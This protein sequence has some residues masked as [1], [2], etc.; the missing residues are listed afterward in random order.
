MKTKLLILISMLLVG[1]A[2]AQIPTNGLI[3]N[4]DFTNG[5]I[6]TLTQN[7]TSL[8]NIN[9]RFG[10]VDN[11]VS[12]NGDHLTRPDLVLPSKA[13]ISFWVKTTNSDT[14]V[15]TIIDDAH[16]RNSVTDNIDNWSGYYFALQSGKISLTVQQRFAA[17]NIGIV[18][19]K[20][21][22]TM[23]VADGNWHHVIATI[24]LVVT[25]S[26]QYRDGRLIYTYRT[27]ANLYIDNVLDQT[28]SLAKS[29][30]LGF[31][32]NGNWETNG[33][34][35]IA[36]NR[37]NS[38]TAVNRYND[39][40]DEVLFYNR[41]LSL[42]EIDAVFN[43]NSACLILPTNTISATNITSNSADVSIVGSDTYDVAYHKSSEA[44]SNAVIV[45]SVSTNS[46]TLTNL[47]SQSEYKV[48]IKK[49]GGCAG[50]SDSITF[51]TIREDIPYYVKKD[52]TGLNDGS[53]WA[54][55]FTDLQVALS[56]IDDN[57][58][59]WIAQGTYTPHAS[60]RNGS[61]IIDKS[62]VEFYGG[63]NG[64]ETTLSERDLK[65]S[66]TILSGDLAGNDAGA[67]G[68]TVRGENAY[69]VVEINKHG[70]VLDGFTIRD[71]VA[72]D[73]GD[74]AAGGA[75]FKA[76][77][78]NSLT[79][80]NCNIKNNVAYNAA[81]IY[82]EFTSGGGTLDIENCIFDNN[83]ARLCT[84]FSAWARS[85]GTFTF[86][87]S[88]SLFSNNETRDLSGSGNST[89]GSS[90]WL[91]AI[92][93]GSTIVNASLINNTYVNNNDIGTHSSMSNTNRGTVG[94]STD[95]NG[96]MNLE[97]ANS[98]F[99]NNTIVGGVVANSITGISATLGNVTVTNSIDEGSFSRLTAANLTNTSNTDPLLKDV[100]NNEFILL[101]GSPAINTGDNSKLPAL[102]TKD[103]LG[104]DRIIE[105]IVDMGPYEF[106]PYA[107]ITYKLNVLV[108]GNG[109]V[110]HP[111]SKS[112]D[113]GTSLSLVAT[114]E[115]GYEFNGWTGDVVGN[116]NTLGVL[117]NNTL[118]VT[119]NFSKSRM[120]VDANATGNNNGLTWADA[121]TDL[122]TALANT[123]NNSEIWVAGG[124]YTPSA[125]DS[126]VYYN[127]TKSGLKIYGGFA[128]TETK[129]SDRIF[130]MNETILS[131]DLQGNDV[132]V[133]GYLDNY[134][135]S[136]R[137]NV[138][139]FHI[140]NITAT[141]NDLLLD[142]LT[143]SDAH[144]SI[145]TTEH[146]G[147]IVKNI[148]VSKLT[149]K[150]CI[151]KNNVSRNANAGLMAEFELNNTAGTRGLLTIENC[152]FTNNMSRYGTS[153]YSAIKSNTNVD[154]NIS[155]TLFNNNT[156]ADLTSSALAFS[157][158]AGWFRMLGST[159]DVNFNFTNNTLVNNTD[160]GTQQSLNASTHAVLAISRSPGFFGT[161][162]AIISNSIFWNNKT[163][164]GAVTRS[165][166]D[167]YKIPVASVNVYNS[168]DENNFNDATIT[169]ATAT[170]DSDPL[171]TN[172]S[173][174]DFTL[175][176]GSPAEDSGDNNYVTTTTDLLGNQRIFNNTVD[177]GSYET[178]SSPSTI[179]INR[180]LTT[181]SAGNGDV[182]TNPNP[183]NGTYVD[184][185][186][187]SVL[188]NPHA[189]YQ[190]DGWSGDA[191][192]ST[193][194]LSV[195][196]D[197][198]KTYTANFSLIKRTLTLNAV[199]GTVTPSPYPTN[200]TYLNGTVVAL[201]ATPD[202]GYQFDGWSGALTGSTSSVSITMDSAKTVT[203]MFS[204]IPAAQR[205]L[206]INATNG[207]VA[208]NPNPINGTYD[209]GTVVGLTAT[210]AAGYQFD[211]W[212]GDASGATASVNVTMDAD[213][214]VTA[215]FSLIQRTLTINA[216]NGT[217]ATNPNPINGTY[218]NGTVVGLTATPA[219]GYQFDG[220]SGDVSGATASVNVTM[221]ADKTVTATFSLIQHALTINAAN[222]S[223]ATN[224]NPTNGT[225]DYGT[226]VGLTATPAAGYQFDGWSG[227]V[228]GATASVNVTMDADKTV[229]ATFSLI[230][231]TLTIVETNGTINVNPTPSN[232]IN[233][234]GTFADG[235]VV[236]LT[237]VPDSGYQFDGW[238][239]DATGTTNPLSITMDA[240]KTVTA[241]F[242]QIQRT[243]NVTIV[244]NGTV[245][246]ASGSAT[247]GT[248]ADG[249]VLSL[250]ATP[251]AGYGFTGFTGDATGTTSPFSITMDADKNITA[252]FSATAS[253]N[254]INRLDFEM[255]PN[256][257]KGN[258]TF[259]L[260]EEVKTIELFNLQGQVVQKFR[261]KKI[262]ISSVAK[263][264]YLV[265]ITTVD[266]KQ[267]IK[268]VVKN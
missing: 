60:D 262:N 250:V 183:T 227:D 152:E 192:G 48:Y 14:T 263:G 113:Y 142:G 151:I 9:D 123:N 121:Y 75:I 127:I 247:N 110:N 44:F 175:T 208:T 51:N 165:I 187:V 41:V 72:N 228:S 146:G 265:K 243:L 99:W 30:E 193:N 100:A 233:N 261:T 232:V 169:S 144:N 224:P 106:D 181:I 65:A 54:N 219:A 109:T 74:N 103:L 161:F 212:S 49:Q 195:T 171:F 105:S 20:K 204:L 88:N 29:T 238:S 197:T 201:T 73:S 70:T 222:G 241:I 82:A 137:Q 91:R 254:D 93:D 159:S 129:I 190:F 216:T 107:S 172:L 258:L 116:T 150:N 52:A 55:A 148:A 147:A 202:A 108:V 239:G 155:N 226:V 143:I 205:T 177:M 42:T 249:T 50:W 36:N 246:L 40:L 4:Y 166:T 163:T 81:G 234:S 235:T 6:G 225:Y 213:K 176:T 120:Y 194:P 255:Y 118:T 154:I 188:A 84:S 56:T 39:D 38:F 180:T 3:G 230:E 80:K 210:P 257:T 23:S 33:N 125:S 149:L 138:N 77:P 140:V 64:T 252:T 35:T 203:A 71:G 19:Q 139:S 2:F 115:A 114:P 37:S 16:A 90:G 130:G 27:T 259:G 17:S 95:Y 96:T 15:K 34:V 101:T 229:T 58:K 68:G 76:K 173:N 8:T 86:N 244:G 32:T 178:G 221:D 218:D 209:E 184:G 220:W 26:G 182:T 131:G 253:V 11:A 170:S 69:H 185:T 47:D 199:N 62:N 66:E 104:K 236:S 160:T 174:G 117:V 124:T 18:G 28:I 196:M 92:G 268:K 1:S 217:V 97:V 119:A 102:I 248:Y 162:N 85:G 89:G 78:V 207:T 167:L 168:I 7:G 231:Y 153:I 53:S 179:V 200:G 79:V 126:N 157:G 135:N 43:V 245:T 67:I 12:L 260:Q 57:T 13:T 59:V 158:S 266:G 112:Y 31:Y 267:A 133:T 111:A 191:S 164:G 141:G 87:V 83:L 98:I 132:N 136:T 240:D 45:N 128:G 214:T 145:N 264:I 211:G 223:V 10:V 215:T 25:N 22:S 46:V 198:D 189:G 61:F 206:T 242:S 5:S 237:A 94:A 63:F 122:N 256:P 251:D 156:V 21:V 186:I 24:D 134:S